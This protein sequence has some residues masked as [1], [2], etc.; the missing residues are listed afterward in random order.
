MRRA[1]VEA[2]AAADAAG[3]RRGGIYLFA[4]A[5]A[6]KRGQIHSR[7]EMRPGGRDDDGARFGVAVEVRDDGR[8]LPPERRVHAVA[9]V[10]AVQPYMRDVVGNGNLETLVFHLSSFAAGRR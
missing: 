3:A 5:T 7:G 4:S 9:F 2:R 10:G 1:I 6:A 8:Q